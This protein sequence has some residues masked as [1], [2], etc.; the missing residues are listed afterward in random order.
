MG[1]ENLVIVYEFMQS[2]YTAKMHLHL[3]HEG[4]MDEVELA[5]SHRCRRSLNIEEI[6]PV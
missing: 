4:F 5:N 2:I 6:E 3:I 1:M